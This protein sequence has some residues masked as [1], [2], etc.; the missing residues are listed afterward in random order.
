MSD[1][2][3]KDIPNS[4][5]DAG[6]IRR[7]VENLYQGWGYN[8]YRKENQLRADDLLVRGKISELL[9]DLRR[10]WQVREQAWRAEHLPPPTREHPYPDAEAVKAAQSMQ[11]IQKQI[12]AFEVKIRTAAVPE[13]DRVWQR[14]RN[15]KDTL[16]HLMAID[17][18]MLES[19]IGMMES[20]S[21]CAV[22]EFHLG[23]L[24]QVWA[25]R[26][27]LLFGAGTGTY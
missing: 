2:L 8:A 14:H 22:S 26:Q 10:R 27:D 12:E 4:I 20:A 16:E 15:E 6:A 13:N 3:L 11:A 7:L 1:P 23:E 21:T 9:S 5:S 17:Q 19:V 25:A 24:E 18:Q